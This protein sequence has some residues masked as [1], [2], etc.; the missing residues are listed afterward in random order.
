M[1]KTNFSK[2]SLSACN[3]RPVH[4]DGPTNRLPQR[5]KQARHS[6]TFV[7]SRQQC[8]GHRHVHPLSGLE[9]DHQLELGCLFDWDVGD[10]AT[11]EE[12]GRPVGPLFPKRVG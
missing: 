2:S 9:V 3:A 1:R 11:A 10:L 7:S 8:L 12:L 4:T 6:M 5:T